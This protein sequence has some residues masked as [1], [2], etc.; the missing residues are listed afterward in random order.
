VEKKNQVSLTASQIATLDNL[1]ADEY[2]ADLSLK[3]AINRHTNYMS[4]LRK[5]KKAFW[6]EM[7]QMLGIEGED[8]ELKS[9]C[10]NREMVCF[11]V[12][13]DDG[14]KIGRNHYSKKDV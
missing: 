9:K 3:V 13:D 5:Q 11:V 10:I 2:G 14:G 6:E 1:N 12:E 4:Q 7:K 8:W